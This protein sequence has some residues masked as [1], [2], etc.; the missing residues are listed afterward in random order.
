MVVGPKERQQ[1]QVD[2][3]CERGHDCGDAEKQGNETL[4]ART[5]GC[6]GD[7]W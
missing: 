7:W 3:G 5:E 4:L 2:C 6:V 1:W